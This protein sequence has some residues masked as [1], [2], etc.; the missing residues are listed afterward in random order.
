MRQA[1]DRGLRNQW[2]EWN[3]LSPKVIPSERRCLSGGKKPVAIEGFDVLQTN[4][5]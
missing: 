2:V 4:D 3:D 5:L 1:S